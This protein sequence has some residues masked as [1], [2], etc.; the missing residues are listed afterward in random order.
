MID[1]HGNVSVSDR[2]TSRRQMSLSAI[3]ASGRLSPDAKRLCDYYQF[4]CRPGCL[5]SRNRAAKD[6]GWKATRVKRLQ[7][8]MLSV[9]ADLAAATPPAGDPDAL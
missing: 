1:D 6:L 5:V 7:E 9:G 8:E 2:Q 4:T 3:S